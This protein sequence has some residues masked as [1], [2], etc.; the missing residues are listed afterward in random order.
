[1]KL[2][3]PSPCYND[4]L[5]SSDDTLVNSD[6][7]TIDEQI[8]KQYDHIPRIYFTNARS[9]FPKFLD[10][11]EKLIHHRIDVTQ[12]S[13]TWHDVT[14]DDYKHKIDILEKILSPLR[15]ITH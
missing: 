12:I 9:V 7:D 3:R 1:M 8:A 14:K 13:E 15:K 4:S 2:F 10:L 11:T 5:S 6:E